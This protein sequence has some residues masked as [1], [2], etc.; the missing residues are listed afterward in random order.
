MPAAAFLPE[1]AHVCDMLA[2]DC[3]HT[4]M[5]AHEKLCL[6]WVS[7][8]ALSTRM[9]LHVHHE[10]AC[11]VPHESPCAWL[12]VGMCEVWFPVVSRK[13]YRTASHLP[14]PPGDYTP[15]L[16][17][18]LSADI[19]IAT[20][21]KWDGI[22]RNWQSRGYVKKVRQQRQAQCCYSSRQLHAVIASKS[23][24]LRSRGKLLQ[25]LDM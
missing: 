8:Y 6:A 1:W 5:C 9:P 12:C 4:C 14:L 19:I 22:S 2:R 13:P 3:V 18:L 10:D 17:A 24:V 15:D 21:E 7:A 16:A 20:P 23:L 11:A 25:V